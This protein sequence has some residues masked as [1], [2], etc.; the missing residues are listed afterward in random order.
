M[1][2]NFPL[3]PNTGDS[4]TFNGT[5][6]I[7]NNGS[8]TAATST[9]SSITINDN[10][11]KNKRFCLYQAQ[12]SLSTSA[13]IINSQ[14]RQEGTPVGK[15]T[16]YSPSAT[17]YDKQDGLIL[18]RSTAALY[19]SVSYQFLNQDVGFRVK[20]GFYL[21]SIFGVHE[22]DSNSRI[23]CFLGFNSQFITSGIDNYMLSIASGNIGLGFDNNDTNWQVA[24][25]R[26]SGGGAG[27]INTGIPKPTTNKQIFKAIFS[28]VAGSSILTISLYNYE[29]NTLLFTYDIT[30]QEDLDGDAAARRAYLGNYVN[31]YF[32]QRLGSGDASAKIGMLVVRSYAE[33]ALS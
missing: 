27:K 33:S 25:P 24:V 31:L 14:I 30:L 4:Y 2:L 12:G 10:T 20:R 22:I 16:S 15:I 5:T 17:F 6:Y 3:N 28:A 18:E 9:G 26:L 1:P 32:Y 21:E 29:T 7:F 13:S 23:T 8:W 19:N 11:I